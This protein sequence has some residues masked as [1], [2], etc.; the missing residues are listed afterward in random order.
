MEE[1][2]G[3]AETSS[4][5]RKFLLHYFGEEYPSDQCDDMCDNCKYPKEKLEV[6]KEMQ[7]AIEVVDGL[8]ERHTIKPLVEFTS[9]KQTKVMKDFKFDRHPLFGKG[10]DKDELFWH[11]IYRQAILNNL[12][13]KEI[14]EYGVL[15]ISQKGKEF[16][17]NPVTIHVP[18]NRDYSD[19]SGTDNVITTTS[20][21][22]AALD[23][24]L[25]NMLKDLRK[26]EGKRKNVQPWIIFSEPSLQDMAT[27]YPINM[28]DLAK[29]SGVSKGI[30][31]SP[32]IYSW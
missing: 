9:G 8:S 2:I 32:S 12:L 1:I 27:Y 19:E 16:L 13:Y 28:D 15:K 14:E 10:K 29:I 23:D 22:G 30:S 17:R 11:S 24:V 7:Y 20:A 6:T 25:M 21:Q 18:L 26:K 5:R 3:Y 31:T 4:C